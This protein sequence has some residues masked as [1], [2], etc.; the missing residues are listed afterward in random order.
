MIAILLVPFMFL[1]GC[2]VGEQIKN[3]PLEIKR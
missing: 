1:V 3:K 2:L